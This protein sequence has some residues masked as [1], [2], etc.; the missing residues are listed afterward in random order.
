MLTLLLQLVAVVD[1]AL[2]VESLVSLVTVAAVLV[3]AGGV[4]SGHTAA[5]LAGLVSAGLDFLL[6]ALSPL[7]RLQTGAGVATRLDGLDTGPTVLTG[8]VLALILVLVTVSSLSAFITTA[9]SVSLKINLHEVNV[10]LL[11]SFQEFRYLK[12]GFVR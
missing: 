12:L 8:R 10:S 2:T 9:L 6:L 4:G 3:G 1:L 11:F 5:V 7:V